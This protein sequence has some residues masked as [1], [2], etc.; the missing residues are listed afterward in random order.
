[1]ASTEPPWHANYPSPRN[2]AASIS[3][4]EVLQWLQAGKLPGEDYILADLRRNDFEGGTI[5]GALN[6]PAQSLYPRIPTSYSL[7]KRAG[8][9]HV[10]WYCGSCGGRG[11][12][13]AGWFVDYLKDQSDTTMKSL[14][15]EG[16]IKGWA[17]A[18]PEYTGFMDEYDASAWAQ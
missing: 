5:R 9:K 17:R 18:G 15:L 4:Q 8:V 14:V 7:L 10:I 6:L 1:M 12:R 2:T 16:G 11:T 13:A 3:R